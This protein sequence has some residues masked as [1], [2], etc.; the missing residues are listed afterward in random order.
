MRMS[1][2]ATGPAALVVALLALLVAVSGAS[3]AAVKLNRGSVTTSTIKNQ[4]VTSAKVK[5]GSLTS[6]DVRDGS[7]LARDF[8]AGQLPA[9]KPGARGPQGVPGARGEEGADGKPGA[10]G[11]DGAKGEAGE[12]GAKGDNGD[13]VSGVTT[14]YDSASLPAGQEIP[15]SILTL[16]KLPGTGTHVGGVSFMAADGTF[17]VAGTYR[18]TFRVAVESDGTGIIAQ[19]K[20]DQTE[21]RTGGAYVTVPDGRGAVDH[22]FVLKAVAGQRLSLWAATAPSAAHVTG[23]QMDVEKLL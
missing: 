11:A 7:L 18:V 8:R 20:L 3:Y 4:A 5:D 12:K 9:G 2:R 21:L 6:T 22:S 16:A 17:T 13:A 15:M 10:D 23:W 14:F 1:S 19:A